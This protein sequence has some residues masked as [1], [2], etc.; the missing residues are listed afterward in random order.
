MNEVSQSFEL[1][2]R[3]YIEDTDIGGIVYYA[4]YLKFFE[5]ARTEFVRS[6]GFE[7]RGGYGDGISYVVHSLDLR[8]FKPAKLDQTLRVTAHIKKLGRAHL[9]FIQKVLDESGEVLVEGNVRVACVNLESGRPRL[10]PAPLVKCL[11]E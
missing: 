11:T 1:P 2:I 6:I 4:N 9:D 5:R 7:L 3:V 8:Y 10:L